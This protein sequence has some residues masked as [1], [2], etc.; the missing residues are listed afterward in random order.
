MDTGP[1]GARRNGEAERR[2]RLPSAVRAVLGGALP[3]AGGPGTLAAAGVFDLFAVHGGL[4]D[5]TMEGGHGRYGRGV[6]VVV[7]FARDQFWR[8]RGHRKLPV[9]LV[10]IKGNVTVDGMSPTVA[11][12]EE[13]TRA[14]RGSGW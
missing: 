12:G 6:G 14:G 11:G 9:V 13:G 4:E 10:S 1:S 5:V 8:R 7:D 3:R 2:D